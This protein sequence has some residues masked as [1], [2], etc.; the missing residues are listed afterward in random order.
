LQ[1]FFELFRRVCCVA[2]MR[3]RRRAWTSIP[4]AMRTLATNSMPPHTTRMQSLLETLLDAP[5]SG[6]VALSRAQERT[7]AACHQGRSVFLH[8][9][10]GAGK[11]LAFQLPALLAPLSHKTIVVSPLIALMQDQVTTLKR[12]GFEALHVTSDKRPQP[13]PEL[14]ARAQLVYATPEF[15][16]RNTEMRDLV[17]LLAARGQ[18]ARL[19]IDEAHCILEWG[20]SFR[21][22]YLELSKWRARHLSGVP[23]TFATATI[24]DEAIG[25]IADMFGMNIVDDGTASSD[26]GAPS[27]SAATVGDRSQHNDL[28]LVQDIQDRQNLRLEVLAKPGSMQHAAAM[29]VRRVGNAPTIVYCLTKK[30]AEDVCLAIIRAGGN[31]GVYHGGLSRKRRDFV[32]K[33][34]MVGK[35]AVICATTAFGMGID[36]PDVQFVYHHSIPATLS[37]YHQQVGRAGRDGSPAQ[38]VLLYAE[39][40]KSRVLSLSGPSDDLDGFA[41]SGLHADVE[42]MASFCETTGCRKEI[43]FTHFG[44]VFDATACNRNCNCGEPLAMDETHDEAEDENGDVGFGRSQALSKT[45][46][47]QGRSA[48]NRGAVEVYYQRV[49]NET[50]RL[51]LPKREALSRRVVE[52]ILA[53]PPETEEAMACIRGV[54]ETK[55][56]RFY[57]VFSDFRRRD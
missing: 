29:I 37:S 46:S 3:R 43:L 44:Q 47:S 9:P 36:R 35:L 12:R 2:N 24:T 18:L 8:V 33:Q 31:A 41:S 22:S 25:H 19:V 4:G 49:L 10:T 7:I 15:L 23:M 39:R 34:W 52:A 27:G 32:Q 1:Y 42:E 48:P 26:H 21:P 56:S 50:K 54:G 51:G 5:S 11:S 16:L 14:L 38:C 40:D 20:N 28:V 6:A 13:L 45:K 53:H 55:A 30:E 17:Q 57:T